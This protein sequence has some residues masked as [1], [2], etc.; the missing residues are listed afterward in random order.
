MYISLFARLLIILG[1]LNYLFMATVNVDIFKYITSPLISRLLFLCIGVSAAMF[2]FDRDYYLPFLGKTVIPIGPSKPSNN[3]T[4]IQLSGLPSNTLVIAW[5]S[6][7]DENEYQDP[8]TAYGDYAN[9]EIVQTDK[10]GNATVELSC[11]SS[12]YVKKFGVMS[13]KLDRHIHYRYQLPKY[14]GL[15]SKVYTKYLD[16]KCK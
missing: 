6:M 11:P 8:F 16:E 5:G 15:F 1:S 13:K 10:D 14:K 2:L 3:L 4:N 12:Y 7:N 9:H